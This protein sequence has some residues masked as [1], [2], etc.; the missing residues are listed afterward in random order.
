MY[1]LTCTYAI[2]TVH[3]CFGFPQ[4]CPFSH[5]LYK[6]L[7]MEIVCLANFSSLSVFT[8]SFLV[9]TAVAGITKRPVLAY[10]KINKCSTQQR[11][12]MRPSTPIQKQL[13]TTAMT[14]RQ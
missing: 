5:T 1:S 14:D 13:P 4:H 7:Y 12:L 11:E 8:C 6:I 3:L 10:L 2:K 9:S